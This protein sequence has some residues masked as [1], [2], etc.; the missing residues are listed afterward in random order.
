MKT[1]LQAETIHV[2]YGAMLIVTNPWK[3]LWHSGPQ[4][5]KFEER[6]GQR[7]G[8]GGEEGLGSLPV[9]ELIGQP[10]PSGGTGGPSAPV[11]VA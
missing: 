2:H 11:P 5:R 10:V 6:G 1:W 4:S 7:R 3:Q 8:S 9:P